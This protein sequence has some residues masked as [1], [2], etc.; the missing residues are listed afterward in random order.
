VAKNAFLNDPILGAGPGAFPRLYAKSNYAHAMA[1]NREDYYRSAHNTYVEILAGTGLAGLIVFGIILALALRSLFRRPLDDSPASIDV[2]LARRTVGYSLLA[3][4]ASLV[5][6]SQPYH[7]Y[8][9][10]FVGLAIIAERLNR[11][12][13]P[14]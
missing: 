4:L 6:L 10:L 9:W 8:I 12:R 13:E 7:K 14:C 11:D 5:F 2:A 3:F 1:E